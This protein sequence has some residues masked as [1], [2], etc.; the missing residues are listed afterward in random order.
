MA[1]L[2][3]VFFSIIS[4]FGL[5]R[6]KTKIHQKDGAGSLLCF[7]DPGTGTFYQQYIACRRG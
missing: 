4:I 6:C 5:I 2:A 1:T 7:P 3:G